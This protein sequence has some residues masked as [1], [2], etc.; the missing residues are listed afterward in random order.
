M[1]VNLRAAQGTSYYDMAKWVQQVADIVIK[2]PVRRVVHGERRQQGGGGGGGRQQRPAAGAADA[3]RRPA[4]RRRQQIAQ[5]LRPQLLRF[6]GFRGFVGLP[7]VDPDRRAPGEPELQH[8]AAEPEHRRALPVG[9]EARGRRSPQQVPEVQDPSSDLEMKSPRINLVMD[10]DRAAAVGLNATQIQ[11]ALYDGLGPKWS[12]TIYGADHPVP[13]AA[14]ARSQVPDA[15]RLAAEDRV[16][17]AGRRSGAARVGRVVQGDGRAAVDQP[18][19]PAAVGVGVVR[20]AAGRVA[21]RRRRR[22]SSR[23]RTR[24]CPRRSPPASKGPPRS[25]SSR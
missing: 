17:D 1:F 22:T 11:N 12:S 9:A 24:C 14:R 16:Q 4:A 6:P 20:P 18:F 8:H 13:R 7:R 25:S 5:Q 21:R 3:A 15:G 2:N 10:R 19:R 23:W